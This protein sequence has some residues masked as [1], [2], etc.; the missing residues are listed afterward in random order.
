M[1]SLPDKQKLKKFIAT[2]SALQEMFMDLFKWKRKTVTRNKKNMKE[3]N[4]TGK[5]KYTE[6]VMEQPLV[7]QV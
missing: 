4:P 7:E 6:K 2:R 3:K 1:K 5:D